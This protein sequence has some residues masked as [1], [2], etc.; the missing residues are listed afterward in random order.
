MY[1][2]QGKLQIFAVLICNN[3]DKCLQLGSIFKAFWNRRQ[4]KESLNDANY[5][6]NVN[7]KLLA[8]FWCRPQPVQSIT[9]HFDIIEVC[10]QLVSKT[11]SGTLEGG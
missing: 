1:K 11:V 5:V 6:W 9:R 7:S 2:L 4:K 3:R 8:L 10:T